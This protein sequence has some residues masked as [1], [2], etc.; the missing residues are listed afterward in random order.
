M[1]PQRRTSSEPQ[2]SRRGIVL[3]VVLVVVSLIALGAYAFS[4]S[5]VI[6]SRAVASFGRDVQ[7]RALAD[8]A[9]E[10]AASLLADRATRNPETLNNNPGRFQ[11]ILLK[12]AAGPKGRGKFSVLAGVASDDTGTMLRAD[13]RRVVLIPP[14]QATLPQMREL[15]VDLTSAVRQSLALP[16]AGGRP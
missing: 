8:S 4:E 5:M 11:N 9:V 3:V 14:T 6:E 7:A 10:L 13:G 12:E 1:Q 2:A 15:L 16:A